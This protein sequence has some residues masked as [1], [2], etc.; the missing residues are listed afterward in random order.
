MDRGWWMGNFGNEEE[1]EEGFVRSRK[2]LEMCRYLGTNRKCGIGMKIKSG[3][4][5]WL[6]AFMVSDIET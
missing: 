1:E 2:L 3:M 4:L 6:V 5:K